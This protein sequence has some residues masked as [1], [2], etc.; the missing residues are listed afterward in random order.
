MNK[1]SVVQAIQLKIG[2]KEMRRGV[3]IA[4]TAFLALA[5]L[6]QVGFAANYGENRRSGCRVI[7]MNGRV[8][9]GAEERS[10][11]CG[12]C[13]ICA[14]QTEGLRERLGARRDT[15]GKECLERVPE[16]ARRQM[17]ERSAARE[18]RHQEKDHD[19]RCHRGSRIDGGE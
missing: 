10:R 17:R 3:L 19:R 2:G 14:D 11:V 12:D 8:D 6:V 1:V 9:P 7:C 16:A 18:T 5:V 15:F 4:I 13:K